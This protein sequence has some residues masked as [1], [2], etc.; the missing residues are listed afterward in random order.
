MSCKLQASREKLYIWVYNNYS[1]PCNLQLIAHG[2]WLE[3]CS[4]RLAAYLCPM[5]ILIVCL[6]NICRSPMA[7]GIL[8]D[9]ANK[10]DL[11]WTVDSAGTNACHIGEAPHPFSIKVAGLNG[12]DIS[13]Q[14]ARRFIKED[15]MEYDRIFAMA[16]DVLED[17]KKIAKDKFD[18]QKVDLFLNELH[19]GCNEDVPDPWY[20]PEEGY[21][22]VFEII[23]KTCK[24]IMNK[25]AVSIV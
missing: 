15:M 3:A 11:N 5:K 4:L 22:E 10:A 1:A 16:E 19:A 21:H 7:E 6:G 17:I 25:Y 8:Q 20:G 18:E 23:N 14:R 9:M 12:I 13:R 2:S 24:K